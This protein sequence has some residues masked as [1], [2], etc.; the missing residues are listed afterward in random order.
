MHPPKKSQK[1]SKVWRFEGANHDENKFKDDHNSMW[2]QRGGGHATWKQSAL[3]RDP[4]CSSST[5]TRPTTPKT[6]TTL[7]RSLR[8]RPTWTW[9][10]SGPET[11]TLFIQ[12]FTT[13]SFKSLRSALSGDPACLLPTLLRPTTPKTTTTAW[14]K[15]QNS[16]LEIRT[17]RRPLQGQQ[18]Q[19]R[20]LL[21]KRASNAY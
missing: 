21:P 10:W 5:P 14:T 12:N 17:V 11:T 18:P 16:G 6:M 3:S 19:K 20:R 1:T 8:V 15:I 13:Y 2:L 7:R 9:T 4:G